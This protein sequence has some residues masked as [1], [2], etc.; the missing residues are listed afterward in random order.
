MIIYEKFNCNYFVSTYVDCLQYS[1]HYRIKINCTHFCMK[2]HSKHSEYDK[3]AIAKTL[4][5]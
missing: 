1:I 4:L 2:Y 5:R 3:V